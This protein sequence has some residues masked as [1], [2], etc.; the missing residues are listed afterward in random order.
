MMEQ[1]EHIKNDEI[2]MVS[3]M[4]IGI[5]DILSNDFLGRF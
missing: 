2:A 5:I 4:I 1:P 3:M